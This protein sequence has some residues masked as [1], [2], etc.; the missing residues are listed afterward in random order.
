M[1][2]FSNI[3][4]FWYLNGILNITEYIRRS[5]QNPDFNRGLVYESSIK[6]QMEHVSCFYVSLRLLSRTQLSQPYPEAGSILERVQ[7]SSPE[8]T[9]PSWIRC[10]AVLENCQRCPWN[11]GWGIWFLV[12]CNTSCRNSPGHAKCIKRLQNTES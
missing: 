7:E 9:A 3:Y 2:N 4:I 8:A 10:D 12:S 5:F 1:E 11:S 6:H